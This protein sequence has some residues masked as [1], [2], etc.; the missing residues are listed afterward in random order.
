MHKTFDSLGVTRKKKSQKLNG[1]KNINATLL[2]SHTEKKK[3]SS[4]IAGLSVKR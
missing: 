1:Q 2:H 3:I 4:M